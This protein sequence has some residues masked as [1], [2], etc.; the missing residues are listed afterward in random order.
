MSTSWWQLITRGP[1]SSSVFLNKNLGIPRNAHLCLRPS[2]GY[3]SNSGWQSQG[4]ELLVLTVP[5]GVSADRGT[6]L[7]LHG[8][9]QAVHLVPTKMQLGCSSKCWEYF[10]IVLRQ[11]R[12]GTAIY[13]TSIQ[14][15]ITCQ[16]LLHL[17]TEGTVVK[18]TESLFS[19]NLCFQWKRKTINKQGH[20]LVK[21]NS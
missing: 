5:R 20:N 12:R 13:S 15:S 18:K 1:V 7:A 8:H 6:L 19:W 10:Y 4:S 3:W 16:A 2:L 11:C 17:G 9:W 14:P 21:T